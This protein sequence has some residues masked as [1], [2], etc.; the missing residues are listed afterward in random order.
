M[1]L[2]TTSLIYGKFI[3]IV[4]AVPKLDSNIICKSYNYCSFALNP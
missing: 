1:V 3:N 4:N 2:T